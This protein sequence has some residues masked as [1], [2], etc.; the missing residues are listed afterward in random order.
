MLS[1]RPRDDSA[2]LFAD[3]RAGTRLRVL[4]APVAQARLPEFNRFLGYLRSLGALSFHAVLPRADIA[5]WLYYRTITKS[6]SPL[7]ASACAGV[8]SGLRARE[9]PALRYLPPIPSPLLCTAIYLRRYLGYREPFAFLSPCALKWTEFSPGGV[10]LVR[11]NATI[12]GIK[13]RLEAEGVDL[14]RFPE[15]YLDDESRGLTVGAFGELG[16][17]LGAVLPGLRCLTSHGLGR[18][19]ALLDDP[20]RFPGVEAEALDLLE[21]YACPA[22]CD[23][24]S[25]VGTCEDCPMKD[26]AP[27]SSPAPRPRP[28]REELLALFARMDDELRSEDFIYGSVV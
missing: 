27:A 6:D 16:A 22:G 28:T 2:R 13:A 17:S 15:L 12:R 9:H 3:L 10:E 5:A 23:G 1:P 20:A 18:S 11:Y 26:G 4:V 24:G 21:P 19:L 8:T 7:I 25:G 14:G